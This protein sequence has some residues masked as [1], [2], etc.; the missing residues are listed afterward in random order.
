MAARKTRQKT[1]ELASTI[2]KEIAK[3]SNRR[4]L[5]RLPVFQPVDEIPDYLRALLTE[6]E[7]AEEFPGT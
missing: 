6:L 7:Q 2:R 4:Q 5:R 3:G 1:K